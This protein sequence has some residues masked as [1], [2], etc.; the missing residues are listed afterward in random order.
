VLRLP[1]LEGVSW[2]LPGASPSSCGIEQVPSAK[3]KP[4][5]SGVKP[6]R[7]IDKNSEKIQ[8]TNYVEGGKYYG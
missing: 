2:Q 3:G 6:L 4:C 1:Q 5:E 8:P 7:T